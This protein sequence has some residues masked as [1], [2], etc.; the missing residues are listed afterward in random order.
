MQIN[1][2]GHNKKTLLRLEEIPHN[3]LY[4]LMKEHHPKYFDGNERVINQQFDRIDGPSFKYV[5]QMERGF[6]AGLV[7]SPK[8]VA[9]NVIGL[10]FTYIPGTP[11]SPKPIQ[12][13]LT[14]RGDLRS[15]V[16]YSGDQTARVFLNNLVADGTSED[17]NGPFSWV[18]IATQNSYTWGFAVKPKDAL[19]TYLTDVDQHIGAF[20]DWANENA[21]EL[22]DLI[23]LWQLQRR[24]EGD[25]QAIQDVAIKGLVQDDSKRYF[26]ELDERL[27]EVLKSKPEGNISGYCI[28]PVS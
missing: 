6:V 4:E 21:D 20:M 14:A 8:N 18:N 7:H 23:T 12:I 5:R 1:H 2:W 10:D 22:T 17:L 27:T 11:E 26:K 28:N 9:A 3:N 13:G 19:I 15:L 25:V 16:G 24:M